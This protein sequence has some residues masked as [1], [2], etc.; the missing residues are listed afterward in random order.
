MNAFEQGLLRY[1]SVAQLKKIQSCHIG[2]GGCG[3]LGSNVAILLTRCGFTTFTIIDYDIIE[4]SN[5]NRQQYTL[6]EIA[7]PKAPTLAKKLAAINPDI[8]C[9][10]YQQ[11]WHPGLTDDPLCLCDVLVEAFDLA[12]TKSAFVDYYSDRVKYLISGNGLAGLNGPPLTVQRCA[13]IFFVG[14]K[15]TEAD[16]DH[17]PMAPRVTQC[18][19][20]MADVILNLALEPEYAYGV[21]DEPSA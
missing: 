20:L 15:S 21:P 18:A 7:Q 5:L 19:A 9:Q 11:E 12:E 14:D 16:C 10:V 4:A 13:N 6:Q 1:L 2:I 3:G 8:S 17:P